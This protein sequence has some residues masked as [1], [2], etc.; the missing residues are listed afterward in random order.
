[1][2]IADSAAGSRHGHQ[3]STTEIKLLDAFIAHAH[4][5]EMPTTS[6]PIDRKPHSTFVE[7]RSHVARANKPKGVEHV[8]GVQRG[9]RRRVRALR[10]QFCLTKLHLARTSCVSRRR[11]MALVVVNSHWMALSQHSLSLD[12]AFSKKRA[13]WRQTTPSNDSRRHKTPTGAKQRRRA[14]KSA[15][16][17]HASGRSS[18]PSFRGRAARGNGTSRARAT[19]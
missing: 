2:K 18:L 3:V 6:Q 11:G 5:D 15:K 12:G 19:F 1:M 16:K 13:T 9:E 17:C 7:L 14:T 10:L 4:P 8:D